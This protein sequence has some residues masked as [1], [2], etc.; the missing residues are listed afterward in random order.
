MRRESER[1]VV[2]NSLLERIVIM[3]KNEEDEKTEFDFASYVIL[4]S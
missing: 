4:C 3:K 2:E 1:L